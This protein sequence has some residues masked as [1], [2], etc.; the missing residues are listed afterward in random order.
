MAAM[1]KVEQK[2][3][4]VKIICWGGILCVISYVCSFILENY[5]EIGVA[6]SLLVFIEKASCYC[7]LLLVIFGSFFLSPDRGEPS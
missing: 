1:D 2:M 5:A 6:G 3:I 4:M 7:G